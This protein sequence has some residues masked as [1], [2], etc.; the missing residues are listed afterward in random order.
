MDYVSEA[1]SMSHLLPT[2]QNKLADWSLDD[3]PAVTL[4]VRRVRLTCE[5]M[6]HAMSNGAQVHPR[7]PLSLMAAMP[8]RIAVVATAQEKP[9]GDPSMDL[10]EILRIA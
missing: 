9:F 4:T 5:S 3:D 7:Y 8:M 2:L 10:L 1:P 6:Q